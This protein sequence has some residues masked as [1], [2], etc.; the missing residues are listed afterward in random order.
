MVKSEAMELICQ[1]AKLPGGIRMK[2][3]SIWHLQLDN[4]KHG[5]VNSK[6]YIQR[7]RKMLKTK[8]VET[9]SK[10]SISGLW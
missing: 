7:V 3:I 6:A 4:I 1:M 10:P 8:L 9:L 2:L 5:E